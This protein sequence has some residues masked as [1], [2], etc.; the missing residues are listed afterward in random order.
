MIRF[1]DLEVGEYKLSLSL[2]S[3]SEP[4]VYFTVSSNNTSLSAYYSEASLVVPDVA[5]LTIG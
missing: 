2:A 3:E 5:P 4:E 1:T